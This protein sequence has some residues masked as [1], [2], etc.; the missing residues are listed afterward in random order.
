MNKD[1]IKFTEILLV[2]AENF[3]ATI[4]DTKQSILYNTIMKYMTLE[5][6]KAVAEKI[7]VT[8][9]YNSFPTIAEFINTKNELCGMS[10]EMIE[11]KAMDGANRFID[12]METYG[13]TMTV[14]FDDPV[15][16]LAIKAL[17]G[18][19]SLCSTSLVEN[20]GYL[21]NNFIKTYKTLYEAQRETNVTNQNIHK[22]CNGSRKT[23][24]GYKWRYL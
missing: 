3:N 21:K 10:D 22:V 16:H 18:W 4:S 9:V 13:K 20:N 11:I 24:G 23:A 5:Q 15:I 17:G 1:R 6:F 8:R 7:L 2:L 12:A 14:V 19:I